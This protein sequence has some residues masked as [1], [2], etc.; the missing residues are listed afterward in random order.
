MARTP[1]GTRKEVTFYATPK[2]PKRKKRVKKNKIGRLE[3]GKRRS[4]YNRQV[5][6]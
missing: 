3:H 1:S 5:N 2:I 4:G 6:N